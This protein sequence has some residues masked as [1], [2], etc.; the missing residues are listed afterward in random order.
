MLKR[1]IQVGR[2][3]LAISAVTVAELV[4]GVK[5]SNRAAS[6]AKLQ[7]F[8]SMVPIADWNQDAAC[9]YGKVRKSL[10][11]K[12]QRIG[13]RDLLLACRVLAMGVTIVANNTREFERVEGLKLENWVG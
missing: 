7:T 5:K 6:R 12:D 10:E 1:L 3:S 9:V 2:Q 4:L 13:E 8:L 11:A